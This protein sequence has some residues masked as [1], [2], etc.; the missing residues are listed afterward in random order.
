M[1]PE[2]RQLQRCPWMEAEDHNALGRPSTPFHSTPSLTTH[3]ERGSPPGCH[4]TGVQ[5]ASEGSPAP[6]GNPGR[7]KGMTFSVETSPRSSTQ[8]DHNPS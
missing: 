2:K 7:S 3:A 8:P 5:M 6:E 1:E 4:I